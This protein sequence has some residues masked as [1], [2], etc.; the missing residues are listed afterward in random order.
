MRNFLQYLRYA[1]RNLSKSPAFT[2]VV[3]I[4]LALGIGA[5]TA[6]FS[7]VYS[8]LLRP[9]P[10]REPGKLFS[11]GESR[12]QYDVRTLGAQVSYPDFLDWRRMGKSIQSFAGYSG[13]AFTF[14]GAGEPKLT[15]ATQVTPNFFSTL[16]V[17]PALGRDFLHDEMRPDGPP[18]AILSY[19]FW[20][21]EF[22]ADPNILGR[23]VHLDGKPATIVGVLPR[24]FQFAPTNSAPLWVPIHQTGDPITRRSLR[25]LST[26][27]RLAPGISP[28]Q[29]RAEMES[30]TA[31]LVS[32]YPKENGSTFFVMTSL[33]ETI[34][35]KIQPLLLVLL[36]AVGFVLLITC[37]NVANL[38]LTR[39]IGRR[40]E[41]AV[42]S[43]LGASRANLIS[44]MLTESLLLSSA[45]AAVGLLGAQSGVTLLLAAIPESQLRSMPY[46]RD[47]GIN[48]PVLIFLCAVTV[49]TGILFGLAPA[50]DA[51]R[52][53]LNEILK[54]ESRGGTS[55]GHA[56]LRNTLVVA[57]IAISLVLV[58]GAGLMLQSLRA[59]LRQSPGF[60]P[61]NVLTFDVNLP[62]A[63]YPSDKN[64]PYNNP[65]AIR[66]DHEFSR[67]LRNSPGIAEVGSTNVV[68]ASGGGGTIRFLVEGRPTTQGQEDECNLLTVNAGYFS[69]LKIPLVTGRL[70]TANDLPDAPEVLVVNRAFAKAYFRNE[71]PL[72]KRIRFTFNAKEPYRQIIGVVEDVA[73]IDLAAPRPALIYFPN[74]Q[75]PNTYLSYLVRTA[76]DPLASVGTARAVLH[77]MDPQLPLI[78]P[79]P[80]EVIANESPSVFLRRYPSY[81]IGSFASLALILAMVGLYG[82]I[83]YMVLQRT[84]EIGIRVA[85]GAQSRDILRMVLRQGIRAAL[86][87]VALGIVAGLA[88][89]RLMTS[90]LYGVTPGDAL[91]FAGAAVLLLIVAIAACSIPAR[92]AVQVDPVVALRYE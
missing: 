65:S 60:D 30:I 5:N 72:G 52:S 78:Q 48:V 23:V 42:R 26:I 45:G 76:G 73:E 47:A 31:Q 41:F 28:H 33:R 6:I 34:V 29:L 12:L 17:K 20:R 2:L 50:L 77:D 88:L 11:L 68:P 7:V 56:R 38:L 74:D 35:G 21:T 87:G 27:G 44:Q 91:T 15:L 43:A 37:A 16:G 4:T 66:F 85:L 63:S 71:D 51:S 90:L 57:E 39:S 82:L 40:K 92:R 8:A 54:D 18:V 22:G 80:L 36:G 59:L 14:A 89:T 55:A 25:W 61:G 58:V 84:R 75:G 86:A 1:L 62:D 9:L 10:Y 49:L 13:D 19:S 64:Y 70:F 81:L 83:S 32:A 67:R 79:Q 3:I 46:L 24:N 53:S 69:A